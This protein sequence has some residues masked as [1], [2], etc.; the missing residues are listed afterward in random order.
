MNLSREAQ[1]NAAARPPSLPEVH[2]SIAI[3]GGAGFWKKALAFSGPGFLVAVGYMDPGNWATDIG[4]GSEF[5][6]RL[7]SV[8]LISNL[9]AILL[10][11]LAAR[12]GIVTEQ[13]LAQICRDRY[14]PRTGVALWIGAE[15]AIAA[16]DLAEVIGSA[17]A[18]NLLFHI[19]LLAGVCLTAFDVLAILY[20][21]HRGFRYLEAVVLLLI[22]TIGLC[23]L[24]EIVIVRPD[25][26]GIARGL[27]PDA[28]IFT[29]RDMLY[30]S[31]SILGATVMPHNLYLHSSLVQ[32][33]A[34]QRTPE[35]IRTAIH[36]NFLDYFLA[37]NFAFLINAAI[38]I[39]AAGA[40]YKHGLVHLAEIQDAYHTLSPLLGAPAASLLFALALLCSGQNST[41]TGTLAGQVVMEGFLKIRLAPWL[42]RLV[43]RTLAIVPAIIVVALY[44]KHGTARLLI[45][46]QVILCLQLPFAVF[47]LLSV[48]N[49]RKVMGS[50]ANRGAI[51]V[52]GWVVAILIA[53]CDLY[54]LATLVV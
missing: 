44:G 50:F 4:G 41:L 29:N 46:S 37:L 40:F 8:I 6:Y 20:L 2:R 11:T 23:Y 19:P 15:I 12:L 22:G 14:S 38:L 39:M 10:Q 28:A 53:V 35:G 18:L 36:Y 33:R 1:A 3:P 52:L 13:D 45:L 49:D 17:I 21:Q 16:C 26:A 24:V 9:I 43:T 27:L 42:R 34:I 5:A 30:I 25:L 48:T 32:T 51:K 47:P 54:Y 7:L 31:I